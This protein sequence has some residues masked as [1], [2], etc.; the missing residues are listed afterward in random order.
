LDKSKK[1]NNVKYFQPTFWPLS[2]THHVKGQHSI[3]WEQYC[4]LPEEEK[5][6]FFSKEAPLKNTL[7]AYFPGTQAPFATEIDADIVDTLVG[8]M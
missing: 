4:L 7:H 5:E 3:C 8:E 2:Y 6:A 1:T